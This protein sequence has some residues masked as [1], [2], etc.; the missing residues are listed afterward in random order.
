MSIHMYVY[1]ILKICKILR[2]DE[3]TC[4]L[5]SMVERREG[6]VKR[7]RSRSEEEEGIIKGGGEGEG[8]E[9]E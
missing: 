4:F 5:K 7:R 1:F 2:V 6:K 8:E 3:V 9:E